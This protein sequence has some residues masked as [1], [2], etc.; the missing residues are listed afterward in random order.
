MHGTRVHGQF[1]VRGI[2]L[3]SIRFPQR[4]RRVP[5]SLTLA[6][7]PVSNPINRTPRCNCRYRLSGDHPGAMFGFLYRVTAATCIS[8]VCYTIGSRILFMQMYVPNKVEK[9]D[10]KGQQTVYRAY[11]EDVIFLLF[12]F[13]LKTDLEFVFYQ[14]Y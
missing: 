11:I 2:N 3:S 1:P 10:R 4:M 5:C 7:T 14:I 8:V 12:F 6:D 9:Q 13:L